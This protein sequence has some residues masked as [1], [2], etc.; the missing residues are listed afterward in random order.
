MKGCGI[1]PNWCN[2]FITFWSDGTPEGNLGLKD[3]NDK[4]GQVFNLVREWKNMKLFQSIPNCYASYDPWECYLADYMYGIRIDCYQ[5]G[6]I[7]FCEDLDPGQDHFNVECDDAWSP[8]IGFW[9][10]LLNYAYGG[11]VTFTYQASEPGMCIFETN[12]QGLL[13]RYSALIYAEG[14]NQ[15]MEFDKI[16]DDSYSKTFQ[17]LIPSEGVYNGKYGVS[18]ECNLIEGDEDEVLMNIDEYKTLSDDT[19]IETLK[20]DFSNLEIFNETTHVYPWE[21]S[22]IENRI[23]SEKLC[24]ATI[25]RFRKKPDYE[26]YGNVKPINSNF[27]YYAGGENNE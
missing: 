25:S 3:L 19:T 13:P 4:I 5:R 23:Y 10:Y 8:N 20:N 1:M 6:Y 17:Y 24:N 12:D 27:V 15:M 9:Y 26:E 21:F 22:D 11:H 16:W 18:L 7:T 14:I 2:N